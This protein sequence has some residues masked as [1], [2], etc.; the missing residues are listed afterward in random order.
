MTNLFSQIN[1]KLTSFSSVNSLLFFTLFCIHL[2]GWGSLYSSCPV[3]KLP[4]ILFNPIQKIIEILSDIYNGLLEGYGAWT[5]TMLPSEPSSSTSPSTSPSTQEPVPNPDLEKGINKL[6][7]ISILF[8]ILMLFPILSDP[9]INISIV[10]FFIINKESL[11]LHSK[12]I[13]SS[14]KKYFIFIYYIFIL[15]VIVTLDSTITVDEPNTIDILIFSGLVAKLKGKLTRTDS[16]S[17]VSTIK[18]E[19][20]SMAKPSDQAIGSDTP[21]NYD[22]VVDIRPGSVWDVPHQTDQLDETMS[23]TSTE[24][25]S[26]S[27]HSLTCSTCPGISTATVD[28]IPDPTILVSDTASTSPTYIEYNGSQASIINSEH[29]SD[30]NT[31]S[32]NL[33]IIDNSS[34]TS[35]I[36]SDHSMEI[37]ESDFPLNQQVARLR[38][39]YMSAAEQGRDLNDYN[40]TIST[41]STN[42]SLSSLGEIITG[43]RDTFGILIEPTEDSLSTVSDNLDLPANSTP[44]LRS[45]S[46]IERHRAEALGALTREYT[47]PA[48]SASEVTDFLVKNSLPL[49]LNEQDSEDEVASSS[50]GSICGSSLSSD[51]FINSPNEEQLSLYNSLTAT[52]ILI[53]FLMMFANILLFKYI[54]SSKIY[55]KLISSNI[56]KQLLESQ[57][58]KYIKNSIVMKVILSTIFGLSLKIILVN[59]FLFLILPV[60]VALLPLVIFLDNI[61]LTNV[62]EANLK[63]ILESTT[64]YYTDS[65]VSSSNSPNICS[66]VLKLITNLFK[67]KIK[68]V[69]APLP[70]AE[71]LEEEDNYDSLVSN[72]INPYSTV[73]PVEEA[74]TSAQILQ[75]SYKKRVENLPWEMEREAL[76]ASDRINARNKDRSM[77]FETESDSQ[78]V[79][80]EAPASVH[81]SGSSRSIS[82]I[83]GRV[84]S[85]SIRNKVRN[86]LNKN[87]PDQASKDTSNDDSIWFD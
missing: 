58:F 4:A 49:V 54:I 5:G 31:S 41:Y 59:I 85:N 15:I 13:V 64:N 79:D 62:S 23:I 42:S 73:S 87:N 69:Y 12:N 20:S 36:S 38:E 48:P 2:T 32:P 56:I 72:G 74:T 6:T 67:I 3:L 11:Q 47:Q 26:S 9:S 81:D 61:I 27:E 1:N 28:S 25:Y 55:K 44:D 51:S 34:V 71:R 43:N 66:K 57:V 84:R 63:L 45:T 46:D 70:E 82:S 10:P 8:I 18:A 65:S 30:V 39:E 75:K 52:N 40:D 68:T 14:L 53:T 33:S 50:S 17:S 37:S 16:S 19:T 7:K 24:S 60:L 77:W 21:Q 86:W 76:L 29:N 80:L 22:D 83:L 35:T 78:S